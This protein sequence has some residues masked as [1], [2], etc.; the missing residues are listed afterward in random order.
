MI[1]FRDAIWLNEMYGDY[2]GADKVKILPSADP[3]ILFEDSSY[4]DGGYEEAE[5]TVDE[6]GDEETSEEEGQVKGE[7]NDDSGPMGNLT[8]LR[9]AGERRRLTTSYNPNRGAH[10]ETTMLT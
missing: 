6:S 5:Q 8:K 2:N 10:P 9:L 1:Y 4:S 7:A 3:F